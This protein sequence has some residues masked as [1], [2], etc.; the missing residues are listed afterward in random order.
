MSFFHN[1]ISVIQFLFFI[2]LKYHIRLAPSLTC[3]HLI[4]FTLFMD[5]KPVTRCSFFFSQYP[6]T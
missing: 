6:E 4:F 1:S 2:T 5:P 3:H